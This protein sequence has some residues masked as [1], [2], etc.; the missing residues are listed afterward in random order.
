MGMFDNIICKSP[1][2]LN[3]ELENLNVRWDEIL[4][5]TKD[6]DNCLANYVIET[7]GNLL[8]DVKKYKYTYYT[9]EERKQKDHDRW[10]IVKSSELIESYTKQVEFHG[11]IEFYNLLSLSETEDIWVV[12]NAFFNYGKLDRITLSRAEKREAQAIKF[13]KWIEEDEKRKKTLYYRL[14]KYS[15]W[16]WLW[17][18]IS[19][20]FYN[21]SGF[22]SRLHLFALQRVRDYD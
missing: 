17:F 4:F 1:L 19:R 15:G 14:R 5:Q 16:F 7:N 2:P 10:N 20:F 22:F 3:E 12:F 11:I 21:L 8:E 18:N 13:N 9:E 6:L